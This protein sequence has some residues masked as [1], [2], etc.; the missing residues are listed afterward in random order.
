MPRTPDT[1]KTTSIRL[2]PERLAQLDRLAKHNGMTRNDAID[3]LI[4]NARPTTTLTRQHRA[5]TL[6]C[7]HLNSRPLA[8]GIKLCSTC[9]AVRGIDGTWR[10]Q[11]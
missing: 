10:T 2:T 6:D 8:T 9:G 5:P 3:A 7:A 11:P 4:A 1:R